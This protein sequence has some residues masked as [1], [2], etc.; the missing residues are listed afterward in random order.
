MPRATFS[1][2]S[3]FV[4]ALLL[5]RVP[6][7][8]ENDAAG[9]IRDV[10][11]DQIGLI[12]RWSFVH[13]FEESEAKKEK[14]PFDTWVAM[15]DTDALPEEDDDF[16]N[17]IYHL[18]ISN[19]PPSSL[20]EEAR[21]LPARD[22]PV[23]FQGDPISDETARIFY[24]QVIVYIDTRTNHAAL[25]AYATA[26]SRKVTLPPRDYPRLKSLRT[27]GSCLGLGAAPTRGCISTTTRRLHYGEGVSSGSHVKA[28]PSDHLWWPTL[29]ARVGSFPRGPKPSRR[30]APRQRTC[31]QARA[32]GPRATA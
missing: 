3:D 6:I 26:E 23:A 14:H 25:S 4:R 16:L 11:I 2:I 21:S 9:Y 12:V 27:G 22:T 19:T 8:P 17:V 15:L 31:R 28:P 24:E 32:Q 29:L 13:E 30:V 20:G 5:D 1:L 7:D 10:D 18:D